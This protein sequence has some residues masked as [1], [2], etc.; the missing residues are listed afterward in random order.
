MLADGL[1][2]LGELLPLRVIDR[3]QPQR[4]FFALGQFVERCGNCDVRAAQV[5]GAR[6]ARVL[7]G[8]SARRPKILVSAEVLKVGLKVLVPT[9]VLPMNPLL[10]GEKRIIA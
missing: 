3:L 5:A 1:P 4:V 7:V 8:P 6:E 10:L 9:S 2:V